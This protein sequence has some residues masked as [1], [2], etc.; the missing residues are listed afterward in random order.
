MIRAF[1]SFIGF[2]AT[3][4]LWWFAFIWAGYFWFAYHHFDWER[5]P[6]LPPTPPAVTLPEPEPEPKPPSIIPEVEPTTSERIY[7]A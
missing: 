6:Q 4:A 2:Q 1:A 3:R 7:E 5:E